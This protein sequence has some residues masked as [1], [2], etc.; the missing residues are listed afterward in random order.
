MR[1]TLSGVN[2]RSAGTVT[3][4][5]TDLEGS[6]RLWEDLPDAMQDALARHDALLRD[7]VQARDGRIV[8]SDRRRHAR[9]VQQRARRAA[10]RPRGRS[11]PSPT[12]RGARPGALRVRIGVHTGDAEIRDGDYYG[13][14]VNRAARLMAVAQRRADPGVARHRGAGARLA[15][16]RAGVRRPRRAS[17]PRP[18]AARADLP[19]RRPGLPDDFDRAP[20]STRTRQPAIAGHV[21]HRTR[22]SGRRDRRRAPRG[23]AASRITGT[24]GVGKTRLALQVRP[25]SSP[26]YPDG[27]WLCELGRGER[28]RRSDPGRSPP[29]SGCTPRPGDVARREHRRVPPRQAAAR[30]CSTTAS[31][32]STPRHD[33]PTRSCAACPERA[34]PGDQPRRARGRRRADAAAALALGAGAVRGTRRVAASD[35]AAPV[36]RPRRG[37]STR[38]RGSTRPTAPR[39]GRSVAASTASHSR[40]SSPRR[41][42]SA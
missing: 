16:R 8:K 39:S 7:A 19:A 11:G 18:R 10:A 22:A 31:T 29:R 12:S 37:P 26:D 28:R 15:R 6:T 9:R 42:S 24:G 41:A 27:A 32:C 2:R 5:F 30:S 23:R 25:R 40:S 34:H 3:F 36:R 33:S 1:P 14:A 20:R 13:T 35:A 4:L 38:V 17:P 21:V